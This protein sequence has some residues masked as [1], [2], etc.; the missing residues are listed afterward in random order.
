MD[1]KDENKELIEQDTL[2]T[3]SPETFQVLSVAEEGRKYK[4]TFT[5]KF[6]HREKWTKPNPEEIKSFIPGTVEKIM[7]K[8]GDDVKEGE[9]LM[10]Y[11][12]MK[13]HNIIHTFH[14]YFPLLIIEYIV[15]LLL[16]P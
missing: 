7:V 5:K 6:E 3:D 11:V 2:I 8:K 15:H 9:E 4:T 1:K 10:L 16:P 14:L 12:A 13:M